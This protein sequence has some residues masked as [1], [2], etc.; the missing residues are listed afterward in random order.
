[1]NFEQGTNA[2]ADIR[3]MPIMKWTDAKKVLSE[4][5]QP[6]AREMYDCIVVDTASIAWQLCEKYI[7]QREGV[8]SIRDIPWGGGWTMLKNEFQEFWR[9]ITLL[10]FGILFI[11][12]SKDKPTE[13]RDEDGEA[14]TALCPDLPNQCY[15]I[16]NSIVDI[17]G[18]L[19]VQMNPDGSS[20][21]F[22]YTRSTPYVFAGSRYQYLAPKIK[23][24][25][26]E[27]VDAIGDAI[28]MAVERDGAQVT[29]HTEIAQVRA[30]PFQETMDE[31]KAIWQAYIG[32][33]TDTDDKDQ[34]LR[35]M[36]D[37]VRSVFG[38]E[39]F[40]LSTAVISQQDLVELFISEMKQLM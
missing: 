13:M 39:D 17:I 22:L 37:I 36:K 33:A 38:N 10:G 3:S 14:I 11:A 32:K 16:I 23:F 26:Q 30:R 7:C 8:D 40:K 6:K 35:Q 9:E 19:Q 31:A 4:L 5:R 2:L 34:R 15:T 24:G 29:D 25:Y 20:E 28:D 1:M 18:Y 27:L 12:H 21:R